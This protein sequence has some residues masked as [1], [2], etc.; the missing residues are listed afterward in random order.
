MGRKRTCRHTAGGKREPLRGVASSVRLACEP[1]VGRVRARRRWL[2]GGRGPSRAVPGCRRLATGASAL[3]ESPCAVIERE[4][5]TVRGC[6]VRGTQGSFAPP[7]SLRVHVQPRQ[8]DCFKGRGRLSE[9]WD[10]EVVMLP[11]CD[12]KKFLLILCVIHQNLDFVL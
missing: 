2:G 7:G 9:N 12:L 11:N 10:C 3:P 8:W 6:G 4:R 5:F 1:Q